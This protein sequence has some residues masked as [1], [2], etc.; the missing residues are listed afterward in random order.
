MDHT[1]T[2]A[3]GAIKP[4]QK[5]KLLL[6]AEL[7]PDFI[8]RLTEKQL[9]DYIAAMRASANIFPALKEKL[10]AAFKAKN[11]AL[12]FQL[13]KS[14]RGRLIKIHAENLVKDFDRKFDVD[15]ALDQVRHEKLGVTI[16][17]LLS[18]LTML[19]SDIQMFLE[20][21]E[22]KETVHKQKAHSGVVKEKLAAIEELDGKMIEQMTDK[23]LHGYLDS[24]TA[25]HEGFGAQENALRGAVS[26]K[27]YASVL[28]W[29]SSIEESLAKI[30]ANG[31]AE[32]CRDQIALC[33]D[34]NGIKQSKLEVFANYFLSSLSILSADIK[35]LNLPVL[36]RITKHLLK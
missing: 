5:A 36:K 13:L 32:E 25:F 24:L 28:R 7:N 11:Y 18:T 35:K 9:H 34:I 4:E 1:M 2:N 23:Q 29:L 3:T 12:V 19:F 27:Q 8:M 33:K 20:E 10:E 22:I 21:L 16:D 31:L 6:I 17:Y 15:Q 30:Y 14:V 26:A